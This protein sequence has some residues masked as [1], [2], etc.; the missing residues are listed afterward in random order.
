MKDTKIKIFIFGV[1]GISLWDDKVG[2]LPILKHLSFV[3]AKK[4]TWN[5]SVESGNNLQDNIST[6]LFYAQLF[7]SVIFCYKN[8]C[9]KLPRNWTNSAR[10]IL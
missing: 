7:S 1:G 4:I 3:I 10:S 6:S 9:M 8:V 5:H 2:S